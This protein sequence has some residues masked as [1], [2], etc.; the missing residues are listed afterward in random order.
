MIHYIILIFLCFIF[1]HNLINCENVDKNDYNLIDEKFPEFK[2]ISSQH[3]LMVSPSNQCHCHQKTVFFKYPSFI[4]QNC[5]KYNITELTISQKEYFVGAVQLF[6]KNIKSNFTIPCLSDTLNDNNIIRLYNLTDSNL[7][8]INNNESSKMKTFFN[9]YQRYNNIFK[10]SSIT[11]KDSLYL[12]YK[13]MNTKYPDD[14]NYMSKTYT[15]ADLDQFKKAFKDYQVSED[16]LWLIKPNSSTAG[17]GIH[18]LKNPNDVKKNDIVTKYISNPLL[19]N[20]RK[21]DLRLYLFVTGHNPLKVYLFHEGL[22]RLSTS[23]YD[24]DLNDLDNLFKHLTNTSVNKN[25]DK[26]FKYDDLIMSIEKVKKYIKEKY[27]TDFSVI[28]DQIKDISI[29]SII[30]M[31]HLEMDKEKYY[32]IHSNNLFKLYGVD[33][34]IDNNFKAWLLEINHGPSLGLFKSE[35]HAKKTKYQLTH[36]MFNIIGLVPYSHMDG[37]AMEGECKYKNSI[38]EAVDQSICEFTR[39]HGG[40]EQIFPLKSNIDYYKKFFRK[41]SPNNQ[42]LWDKIKTIDLNKNNDICYIENYVLT[43]DVSTKTKNEN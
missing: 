4:E 6:S 8:W 23:T 34:I 9:L 26:G 12:N 35:N 37:H 20:N 19:I 41:T 21:F 10:H 27:N 7:Y 17:R 3:L 18:F 15:G 1:K 43:E 33:I 2:N 16:N 28:W 22:A 40:F 39:P 13:A 25:N 5:Q 42:A 30:S 31:N 24:L 32:K 14:Y 11:K 36:D 38:E 29:K